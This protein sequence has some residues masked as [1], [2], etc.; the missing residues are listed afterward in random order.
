MDEADDF[1]ALPQRQRRR[2][3]NITD[4]YSENRASPV[5]CKRREP[6]DLTDSCSPSEDRAMHLKDS[7]SNQKQVTEEH[8]LPPDQQRDVGDALDVKFQYLDHTA[9]I[10]LHAWGLTLSEAF[11]QTGLA[12]FNY[13]T[14]LGGISIDSGLTRDIEAQGHD[15]H[16]LLYNFLDGLLSVFNTDLFVCR[17]VSITS[18][19]R[20]QWKIS[21]KGMG[22]VFDRCRHECGTEIKAI[23]YSAMRVVE[24]A[25]R[26]EV[27]VIVDI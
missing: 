15:L 17:K 4:G 18:F 25:D 23:T 11:E 1:V 9:D 27:F 5:G 7:A 14:P 19:D 6:D 20:A 24:G 22:E 8:S 2:R 16:S 13:I 12:M 3:A 26:A 21:A 10:Q